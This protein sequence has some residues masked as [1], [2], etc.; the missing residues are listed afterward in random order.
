MTRALNYTL[1][2]NDWGGLEQII[3]DLASHIVD[4]GVGLPV[5]VLADGSR[6]MS[7]NWDM[8]SFVV[9]NSNF[10]TD[11][12]VGTQPYACT[13]TTLNNNLNADLLD[14][15]E[16]SYYAAASHLH[17]GATLQHDGVNSDGGAFSFTTTGMVTFNQKLAVG[18]FASPIDVTNTREHGVELHFSGNDYNV[19]G[20][21]SR[22]QLIT[23][24]TDYSATGGLFQAA[25]NDNVN[26][27]VLNGLVAEAIGKATSNA[28]TISTMRGA[29]V[30]AEWSAKDTVTDLRTLHVRTHTRDNATEG[31]FSKYGKTLVNGLSNYS[32]GK[33]KDPVC[34]L[35]I[36]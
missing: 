4:E 30:G 5:Y 1:I 31:Y 22:A 32:K 34:K 8:G 21:R 14:G 9:P 13:S 29:L 3:N 10:I 25:N 26:V 11:V 33:K 16:G 6:E 7:A 15:Q 24:D 20:I 12:S 17:D 28:A 23:T 27:G 35:E 19:T 18:S 2:P 36:F